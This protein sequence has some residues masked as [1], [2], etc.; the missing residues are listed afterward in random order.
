MRLNRNVNCVPLSVP[1]HFQPLP[2]ANATLIASDH[3]PEA[4][5]EMVGFAQAVHRRSLGN[6]D[7]QNE[8]RRSK[9]IKIVVILLTLGL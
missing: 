6:L 7:S 3:H 5:K 9:G 2:R 8:T 1:L 4:M